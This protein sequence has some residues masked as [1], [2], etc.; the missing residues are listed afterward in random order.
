[1]SCRGIS[2]LGKKN[3]TFLDANLEIP[4]LGRYDIKK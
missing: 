4:N 3:E 2:S 1:M